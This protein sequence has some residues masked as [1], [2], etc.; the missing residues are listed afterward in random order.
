MYEYANM[1]KNGEG[2]PQ[3]KEEAV[4]YYKNAS[5]KGNEEYA[6]MMRIGDGIKQDKEEAAKLLK[7][8]ADK[9]NDQAILWYATMVK[10]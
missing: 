3:N 7:N 8:S 4:K 9:G 2:V 10:W 1:L 6:N 5:E